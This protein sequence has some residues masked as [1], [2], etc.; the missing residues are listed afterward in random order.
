MEQSEDN[1]PQDFGKFSGL[2][3]T[4]YT[5]E[6][7]AEGSYGE[8][9][10]LLLVPE[11]RND[12]VLKRIHG[13]VV[14][15]VPLNA[16]S[17]PG[18]GMHSSVANVAKE[19]KLLRQMD[20]VAGFSRLRNVHVVIGKYPEIFTKAFQAYKDSNGSESYDPT[21]YT[22]DQLYAMFEMEDAGVDVEKM[23]T[24]AKP[25]AFRIYDVF[26][27]VVITLALA[28]NEMEFEHRDLHCGNVCIKACNEE[29]LVDAYIKRVQNL[30]AKPDVLLGLSEITTT[31]I[32]YTHSRAAFGTDKDDIVYSVMEKDLFTNKPVDEANDAAA[33]HQYCTQIAMGG[34]LADN[35]VSKG[36]SKKNIKR[37]RDC[38]D[39]VLETNVIWL[40]HILWVLLK[41]TLGNKEMSVEGVGNDQSILP[42]SSDFSAKL[43]KEMY[44]GL[45]EVQDQA[46][47]NHDKRPNSANELLILADQKG[48]LPGE[49]ARAYA[50]KIQ[51]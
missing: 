37:D 38:P 16:M 27:S 33:M 46:L 8:V 51:A 30:E 48:W 2:L 44:I 5:I 6:K 15:I 9:Y 34:R 19:A 10:K 23:L 24:W 36:K 32:D 29:G 12:R 3:K 39:S 50:E 7:I 26:W 49:Q 1:W 14:K 13:A 18:S 43:Q 28:E 22:D 25:S 4:L 31:I 41:K 35:S 11:W 17:G 47:E 21:N 42:G 40:N 45:K 20:L